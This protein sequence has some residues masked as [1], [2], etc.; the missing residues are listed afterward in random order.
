MSLQDA[1]PV[2]QRSARQEVMGHWVEGQQWLSF[3]ECRNA[4]DNLWDN[5]KRVELKKLFHSNNTTTNNYFY[6]YY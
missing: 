5:G 2:G 3:V 4:W 1:L 6:Y